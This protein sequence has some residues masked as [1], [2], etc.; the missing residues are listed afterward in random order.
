MS[1]AQRVLKNDFMKFARLPDEEG[2]EADADSG[3]KNCHGDVFRC[4]RAHAGVCMQACACG[5]VNEALC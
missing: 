1:H 4:G 2:G 5:R 3:W